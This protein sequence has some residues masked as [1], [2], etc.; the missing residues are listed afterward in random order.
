MESEN[1]VLVRQC[2]VCY[3]YDH[4]RSDCQ[5]KT[6]RW[7]GC[8]ST[9]HV[10]HQCTATLKKCVQ[11]GG[12]HRTFSSPCPTRKEGR[13]RSQQHWKRGREMW[14]KRLTKPTLPS[15]NTPPGRL[16]SVEA[17][18]AAVKD[19][20]VAMTKTERHK[21]P[22]H[23]HLGTESNTIIALAYVHAQMTNLAQP[24]TF[25]RALK[26]FVLLETI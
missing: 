3:S 9:N 11:C 16:W 8:A 26:D 18:K 24:D 5:V 2:M 4:C 22:Y 21:Q 14:R 1:Y 10:W 25:H 19:A 6:Q 13:P 20:A 23:I 15:S 17:T 7:P 12:P